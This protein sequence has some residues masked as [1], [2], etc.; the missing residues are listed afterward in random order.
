LAT[1][2]ENKLGT[3]LIREWNVT[4]MDWD[5]LTEEVDDLGKSF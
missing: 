4:K 3:F 1:F 2:A 5:N